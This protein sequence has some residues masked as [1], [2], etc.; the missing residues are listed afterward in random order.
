MKTLEREQISCSPI[1]SDNH[2]C[3]NVTM[4]QIDTMIQRRVGMPVIRITD[5]TWD[6]LKRWAVPLEDSPEDA[7]RKVLDAAE[8]HLKCSQTTKDVENDHHKESLKDHKTQLGKLAKGKRTPQKAYR[9]PIL[10]ALSELGG[11]A[12]AG[13]VLKLV[14]QQMKTTLIGVDYER[15]ASGIDIRW[16]NAA[17]WERFDLV[18][19]GLMKSGS[20]SGIWEISDDGKMALMKKDV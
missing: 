8:E 17:M 12:P 4:M 16:H 6:R 14:E 19:D 7:V 3:Y 9:R 18:K 20:P 15:L 5:V 11:S 13:D 10:E 1:D 2:S